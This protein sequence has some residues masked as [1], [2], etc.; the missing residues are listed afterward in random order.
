V[1]S[2]VV[3]VGS[4]VVVVVSVVVVVGSVVVAVGSAVVCVVVVDF[5]TF[6]LAVVIKSGKK[7]SLENE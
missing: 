2:V 6:D 3:V 7:C 5:V 4:V 1:V